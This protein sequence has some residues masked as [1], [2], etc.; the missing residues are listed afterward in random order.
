MYRNA[1]NFYVLTLYPVFLNSFFSSNSLELL[2][3]G[4]NNYKTKGHH[5]K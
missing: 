5:L 4:K 2:G 1:T 3:S